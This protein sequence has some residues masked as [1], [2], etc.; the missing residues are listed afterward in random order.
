MQLEFP[1][2]HLPEP[3]KDS[4]KELNQLLGNEK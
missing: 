3:T 4:M 2:G 1:F